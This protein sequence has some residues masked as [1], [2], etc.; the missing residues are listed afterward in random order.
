MLK[1]FSTGATS[2]QIGFNKAEKL[3]E[4]EDKGVNGLELFITVSLDISS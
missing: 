1:S 4:S 3:M 2:E